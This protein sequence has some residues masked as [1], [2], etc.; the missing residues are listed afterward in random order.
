MRIDW[1]AFW[2]WVFM[3]VMVILMGLCIWAIA[4]EDK[5]CRDKGG[6]MVE[7]GDTT[8]IVTYANNVPIITTYDDM[9]CSKK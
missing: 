8:T 6:K 3:G 9:E 5:E 1:L 4:L 2:L 7:T